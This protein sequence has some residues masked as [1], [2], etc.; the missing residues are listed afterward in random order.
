MKPALF[1]LSLV[2]VS[3]AAAAERRYSLTDFERVQLE[4]PYQVRLTT[5]LASGGSASGSEQ[6]L[7][8]VSVEV[9]GSTLRIRP[10]RSAWGGYPGQG[11]G[12]PPVIVVRT[13]ALRSASVSG[14][15]SLV[16]DKARGLRIDLSVAGSG[17][18]AIGNV[19]ADNLGITMIGSGKVSLAGRARQLKAVL[20]GSAELQAPGLKADDVQITAETAGNVALAA[21]RSVKLRS[22]GAGDVTISG[23]AACTVEA[24]GSGTVRCGTAR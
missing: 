15:G 18:L 4:G 1:L 11:P 3:P 12:P 23:T 5:G 6:A 24:L 20:Q 2:A 9:Q 19:D 14:A 22:T 7:D 10:N 21:S 17:R 16:V 13:R 8:R